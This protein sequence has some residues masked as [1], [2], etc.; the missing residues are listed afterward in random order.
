[1]PTITLPE[2]AKRHQS[3]T[4]VGALNHA[5]D[6]SHKVG[7]YAS[8]GHPGCSAMSSREIDSSDMW[9]EIMIAISA[10]PSLVYLD[11]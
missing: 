1:M 5:I 9:H 7:I 8:E 11:T 2:Y 6:R 4:L 3:R 10:D